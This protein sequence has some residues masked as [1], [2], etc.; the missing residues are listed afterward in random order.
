MGAKE[1]D[2]W[3]G[4]A[5]SNNDIYNYERYL[6]IADIAVDS[7]LWNVRLVAERGD[8]VIHPAIFGDGSPSTIFSNNQWGEYTSNLGTDPNA[9]THTKIHEPCPTGC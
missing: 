7:V 9:I 5:I 8:D 3:S 6:D 1:V 2:W 4:A